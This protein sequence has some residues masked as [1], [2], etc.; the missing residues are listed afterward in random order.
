M[1]DYN[2]QDY[3][4]FYLVYNAFLST[5]I[6]SQMCENKGGDLNVRGVGLSLKTTRKHRIPNTSLPF[7]YKLTITVFPTFHKILYFFFDKITH[8][9]KSN[10]YPTDCFLVCL[11]IFTGVNC[12]CL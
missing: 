4:R 2:E 6:C 1:T 10:A 3:R 11:V 9:L 5:A 12:V 7:R 8:N